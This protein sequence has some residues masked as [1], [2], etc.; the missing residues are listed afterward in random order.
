M[1]GIAHFLDQSDGIGRAVAILL[2]LMSISAWVV[3]VWKA[4]VLR[5][6]A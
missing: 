2:L 4:V 3:I 1:G 6:H 5:V